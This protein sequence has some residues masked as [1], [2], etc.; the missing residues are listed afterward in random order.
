MVRFKSALSIF[1]FC[2]LFLFLFYSIALIK[3]TTLLKD[4]EKVL[5]EASEDL[6]IVKE[7]KSHLLNYNRNTILLS[8]N[9]SESHFKVGDEQRAELLN[10]IKMISNHKEFRNEAEIINEVN[11]KIAEYFKVRNNLE[12]ANLSVLKRYELITKKLDSAIDSIDQLIEI[13]KEQM[14][15]VVTNVEKINNRADNTALIMLFFGTLI[16]IGLIGTTILVVA[17]PIVLLGEVI[18]KYKLGKKI[19]KAEIRGLAEIRELAANF[20][21]M[22]DTLEE[23]KN[24]QL[25]FIASIAHDLRNP[26]NSISMAAE[27]LMDEEQDKE[28]KELSKAVLI[29]VKNLDRMVGDLL[30]TTRIEAGKLDLNPSMQDVNSI[31]KDTLE[32]HCKASAIHHFNLDIPDEKFVCNCDGGR[33][34]QVLNNFISN[35]IKYSPMGGNVTIKTWSE[36]QKIIIMI[37]DQGIG[38]D[39]NELE[40]IFKPFHRSKATKSTIPGIG[41]GLSS[42]RRL[43]EAHG[44]SIWVESSLGKGSSF[45]ISL[46]IA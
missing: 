35:A 22:I 30:D 6:G 26:L 21:S 45:Y 32:L 25:R 4:E 19:K 3:T 42:S 23:N 31:I 8:L 13:H 39:S 14:H 29:Q 9:S 40:N 2:F 10:L 17:H 34:T 18:T 41:L 1:T 28:G 24:E 33:L 5:V 11:S 12:K 36:S 43:I 27:L 15:S 20:N 44:G 7:I 38:I 46:P 16:L 37:A